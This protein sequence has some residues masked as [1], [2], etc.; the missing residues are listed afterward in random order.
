MPCR[1]RADTIGDDNCEFERASDV[2]QSV[3]AGRQVVAL[4]G[5]S[6]V[7]QRLSVAG[8]TF[9]RDGSAAGTGKMIQ[10]RL[11]QSRT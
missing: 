2:W 7:A 8:G 5:K 1:V 10:R 4:N 3:G 11:R 6:R 9:C